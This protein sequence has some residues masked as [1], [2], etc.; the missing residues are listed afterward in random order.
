VIF[1]RKE[2]VPMAGR[3]EDK[4]ALVT[5]AGSGIGKACAVAF[6]REGA[7][8]VV[9]DVAVE[10]GEETTRMIRET[11]GEAI[12]VRCDVSRSTEVDALVEAAVRAFGRLDCACNNAGIGGAQAPTADYPEEIWSRVLS[13]NLTGV[14][15]CMKHEIPRMLD[16]GR[17]G[18]IVNISSILGTVGFEN[19]SAYV[20][21]KHGV[22]GL[23]RTAA[24]EYA[25]L[26]IRVNAVCPGFIRTPILEQA[27][28]GEGS[29]RFAAISALHPMGRMGIPEEVSESV[30]WL[31]SDGASFVTG[32]ALLVDGGYTAR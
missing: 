8:V 11:G 28:I 20:A 31:C 18:A 9:S 21:A 29:E 19:S 25:T 27:G 3:F 10:G 2:A 23:S 7:K 5:G 12:F 22:N 32:H 15:F 26:G 6:A 13:V 14:W 17:G 24:L 4:V 1:Y 30:L 16:G